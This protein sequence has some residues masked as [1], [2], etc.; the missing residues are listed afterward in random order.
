MV[1]F[2]FNLVYLAVACWIFSRQLAAAKR[3]GQLVR[4][5]L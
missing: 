1:A 5:D 4:N 2:V 3:S